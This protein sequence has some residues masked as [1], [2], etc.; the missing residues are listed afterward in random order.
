[1]LF[2]ESISDSPIFYTIRKPGFM[3]GRKPV[4]P[5]GYKVMRRLCATPL[6]GVNTRRRCRPDG[7]F[8][9]VELLITLVLLGIVLSMAVPAISGYL[10]NVNLK[11][12]ARTLSGDVA[13]LRESAQSSGRT[14]T[15]AYSTGANQ[16]TMKWDSDGVGTYLN[17]TNYPAVRNLTDY[18]SSVR[19]TSVSQTPIKIISSGAINPFATVVLTNNRG[20][21]A[22]ITTLI[23]GRSHVTYSMQ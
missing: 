17:V 22:T 2:A 23:T 8:T 6:T 7:G 12:A 4:R 18:G 15:I 14:H 13:F 20:S 5:R 11:S 16:C 10:D 1:M 9:M 21:T 19:I 3:A